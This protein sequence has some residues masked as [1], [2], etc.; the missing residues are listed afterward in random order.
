MSEGAST[1]RLDAARA[2]GI[3]GGTFDPVHN[4]HL[5]LAE[6]ARESLGLDVVLFLPAFIAPHKVAMRGLTPAHCRL[7]MLEL[8]TAGNPGFAISTVEID[9]G[10][11]GYTVDTLAR[12]VPSYPSARLTLLIGGDSARDFAGWREPARI[13]SMASIGVMARPEIPL[14]EELLPGV[15]YR[16]VDSPLMAI[17]S[18]DIRQRVRD[19]RSIR[20][21]VPDQVIEYISKHGLYC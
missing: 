18:T 4:A 5:L 15:G 8:A 11:V 19:G 13:A 10:E 12:L 3:Y 16:R 1:S 21:R 7:E 9:A 14:P 2:I 20:Y 6:S 17:S